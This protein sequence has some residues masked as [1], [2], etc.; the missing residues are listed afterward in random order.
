MKID[1]IAKLADVSRSAVS[2]ALNGKNG[3]SQK[4]REKILK[5]AQD[6]GYIPRSIVKAEHFIKNNSKILRFVACT[7]AG[8]VT[9]QFESLPFF[10]ELINNLGEHINTSG[11][12]LLV[13]SIKIE[14]LEKSLSSL[15][16]QQP[17]SG[18][19]LLGTNLSPSQIETVSK[20]QPNLVV[21]D[22][23]F[24]TMNV[25]FVVMN[26]IY[27]AYH[28]GAHLIK[29]G[30]KNIGYIE[31]TTRMYNF[32]MRKK[33]FFQAMDEFGITVRNKHIYSLPPTTVSSQ[34]EFKKE[35]TKNR[36][37]LPTAFF[38]ECDYMAISAIKSFLELG[39]HIPNDVSIIGFDNI[40]E[41]QVISPELSTIHVKKDRIAS[42]AVDMLIKQ[43]QK[44]N[45][46]IIKSFVNTEL[47]IRKSC[48]ELIPVNEIKTSK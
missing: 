29:L 4:T 42:L 48:K 32:N 22:T 35:I 8:I 30:H 15:E 9:E 14:E 47:I 46:D 24:E 20:I 39:I 21:L 19:L 31:S 27:G 13:S 26:N 43:I 7:N 6:H 1:D 12:S 5:I 16:Q 36:N 38:C 3:V 28:A 17:S 44:E 41:S 37:D 25:N 45:L 33:G 2:L 40:S 34:E 10:M 18:I 23:C 11:Y